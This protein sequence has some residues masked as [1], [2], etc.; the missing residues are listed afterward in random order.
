MNLLLDVELREDGSDGDI[1]GFSAYGNWIEDNVSCSECIDI[2][3]D[4]S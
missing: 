3:Q 1:A 4:P 2:G